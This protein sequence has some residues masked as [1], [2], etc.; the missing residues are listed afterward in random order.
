MSTRI[1]RLEAYIGDTLIEATK[2]PIHL[3]IAVKLI[4]A[5]FTEEDFGKASFP[6]I[7]RPLLIDVQNA[8]RDIERKQIPQ[9]TEKN[10]KRLIDLG[11]NV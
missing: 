2:Y 1:Q 3:R 7:P 10:I 6:V 5:G 9:T 11:T 4:N 8:M